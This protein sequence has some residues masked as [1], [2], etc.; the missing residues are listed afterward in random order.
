MTGWAKWVNLGDD[1]WMKLGPIDISSTD[2]GIQIGADRL[3]T[4]W[5]WNGGSNIDADSNPERGDGWVDWDS[6]TTGGGATILAYW[7]ETLYGD[8]YAGSEI[9]AP[10]SPPVDRYTATYLIQ[11]GGTIR[12]V[13]IQSDAGTGVPY[14]SEGHD[15]FV[16]PDEGNDYRGTLGWLDK[17]G[18]LGSR[19]GTP[20]SA[21]PAGSNIY[22]DGKIYH[23]SSGLT[24]NNALTFMNGTGNQKGSGTI[25]VD[26]D[27]TINANLSYQSGPVSSRIDNLPSVAWIVS[28]SI[29]IAPTVTEVVGVFYSEDETP[30]VDSKYGIRTGTTGWSTSDEQLIIRGMFIATEIHLERLF[31]NVDEGGA[32]INND[33][34]EQFFFDG[35]A[36]ANPPPGLADIGKGLPT[37]REARP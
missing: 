36:L 32:L 30:D 20:E 4:G 22:L 31:I 12:A 35:R 28:G 27:L 24:L 14:I 18:M 16:L 23:Y 11:A 9:N 19:Y 5:S 21:L 15:S 6:V 26:G 34:A 13:A 17:A 37:L 29:Y 7:Y 8:I 33:P 10:F 25:I 1:G 2:Y 3:F